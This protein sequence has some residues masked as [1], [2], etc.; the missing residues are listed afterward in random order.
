MKKNNCSEWFKFLDKI[1]Q[2]PAINAWHMALLLAIIRLGNIQ[3]EKWVIR[4]SRSKLMK[5]SHIKTLPSYHK[6]FKQLQDLG[7][8][9]YIPSYDPGYKSTVEL[10][11][12]LQV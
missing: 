3:D 12:N 1:D 11:P 5:L 2:D 9:R 7:Y 4:V 10:L 8:I 6:Y